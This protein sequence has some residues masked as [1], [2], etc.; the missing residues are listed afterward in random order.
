MVLAQQEQIFPDLYR[1]SVYLLYWYKSASTDTAHPPAASCSKP[2]FHELTYADV[3]V[4]M[5]TYAH[6]CSRVL[7]YPHVSSRILTY[8]HI[9]PQMLTYTH[10]C[11]SKLLK[12][13]LP[14]MAADC[15]DPNAL[16]L[17]ELQALTLLALLVQSTNADASQP[18]AGQ[19][20]C[21][22]ALF[23]AEKELQCP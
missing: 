23:R 22:R 4:R 13:M 1:Y 18:P 14:L 16:A 19:Q 6:E 8:P 11:Y 7:T 15:A 12:A 17:R 20:A 2:C 9:F 10:V 3:C 5:L 21:S